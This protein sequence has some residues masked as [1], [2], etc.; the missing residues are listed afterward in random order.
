[1]RVD[2][3]IPISGCH[4]ARTPVQQARSALPLGG[5]ELWRLTAHL[6]IAAKIHPKVTVKSTCLIVD[7]LARYADW[8]TGEEIR[9]TWARIIE[10]TG[11]SRSTVSSHLR[12][13]QDVGLLIL[14]ESGSR[15]PGGISRAAEYSAQLPD[16][17][18]VRA[19]RAQAY[20]ELQQA[21]AARPIRT[22]GRRHV[23]GPAPQRRPVDRR[24]QAATRPTTLRQ[25]PRQSSHSSN[26]DPTPGLVTSPRTDFSGVPH[27]TSGK[28]AARTRGLRWAERLRDEVPQFRGLCAALA[29][30][31]LA[32]QVKAGW[33]YEDL[34]AWLR[35]D[36][37][38][39]WYVEAVG[40]QQ[41]YANPM[42]WE[43]PPAATVRNP[44]GLLV[45]R[46]GGTDWHAWRPL[47]EVRTQLHAE[48]T[49]RLETFGPSADEVTEAER[50]AGRAL[51]GQ[52][53]DRLA[54]PKPPKARKR[55]EFVDEPQPA[56]AAPVVWPVERRYV[57]PSTERRLSEQAAAER[58]ERGE[59]PRA[60]TT[61]ADTGAWER[62][63]ARLGYDGSVPITEWAIQASDVTAQTSD[64]YAESVERRHAQRQAD[65]HRLAA[66]R[67]RRQCEQHEAE[68]SNAA[69]AVVAE[70]GGCSCTDEEACEP[71]RAEVR[72]TLAA[73][74]GAWPSSR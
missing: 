19:A 72:A 25:N 45:F 68:P 20:A 71:C 58:A 53:D 6:L 8:T 23:T 37:V 41:S 33:S 42:V 31:F 44:F 67:G 40:P 46:L 13:L 4:D 32:R 28:P 54:A 73:E 1:M 70:P 38:P 47:A 5:V 18:A 49:A 56:P 43:L 65:A 66:A 21:Q 24:R 9:P 51:R 50:E 64:P 12:Y 10:E 52:A 69:A 55:R 2:R 61:P 27:A 48:A 29:A 36:R 74:L 14:A 17:A 62:M 22:V 63:N 7:V 30:P 16:T 39:P 34:R 57:A 60:R 59:Q 35:V 3:P 11:L 26:L 15:Y